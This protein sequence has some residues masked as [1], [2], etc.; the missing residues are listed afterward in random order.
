MPGTVFSPTRHLARP[1][2]NRSTWLPKSA[3]NAW[4]V[5]LAHELPDPTITINAVHPCSVKSGMNSRCELEVGDGTKSR[6]AM[7]LLDG[8]G[9]NGSFRHPGRVPAW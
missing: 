1:T 5:H 4:T 7:A 8:S 3:V 2:R 9:P 6:V